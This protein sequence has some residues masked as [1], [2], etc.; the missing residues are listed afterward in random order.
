MSIVAIVSAANLQSANASLEAANF[1]PANFSVTSYSAGRATHAALHAW[2][3]APFA[4]AVKTLAGGAWEESEGDPITRTKALIEAQG[5]QWGANAPPLTGSV[6]AGKLYRHTDYSLWWVVQSYS[7]TTYPDPTAIPALVRRAR[8]P[9]VAEPWVQP[10]DQYDAYRL[11]DPFTGSPETCTH[12]GKEWFV[13]QADG[14]GNNV[15]EPGTYGWTEK[16]QTPAPGPQAWAVGQVVAV[17]DLRTHSGKT[18]KA[19]VAH[20]THAGWEPSA[21]AW[22]VWDEV[23]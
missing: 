22:A 1:G 19:K 13:S 7:A 23:A 2:H 15:W 21:A 20:T 8:R 3:D 4:A 18:W 16:G 6:T 5:A 10:I 17:G 11:V 14:A 9:G 12:N